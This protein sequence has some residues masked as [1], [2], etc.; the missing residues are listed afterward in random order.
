MVKASS[1]VTDVSA[2]HEYSLSTQAQPQTHYVISKKKG[3]RKST[4]PDHTGNPS[5]QLT[6]QRTKYPP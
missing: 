2:F 1:S 6:Q 3:R 5:Y 4:V